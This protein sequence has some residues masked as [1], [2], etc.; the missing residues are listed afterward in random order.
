MTEIAKTEGVAVSTI[1]EDIS[2]LRNEWMAAGVHDIDA[3]IAM[4]V[5]KI[6]QVE[7]EAWREWD[8]SKEQA[9][10][11]RTVVRQIAQGQ[12]LKET[13]HELRAKA[14]DSRYLKII[15]DCIERR[16]KLLGLERSEE[17]TTR[18]V[19]MVR[20]VIVESRDQA[21]RMVNYQEAYDDKQ[22]PTNGNGNGKA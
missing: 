22:A 6:N 10:V 15:L 1:S 3:Q 4:E 13:M 20:E 2:W 14:G 8:R 17:T 5:E 19:L 18:E 21:R 9:E 12:D 7:V 16:S 11:F